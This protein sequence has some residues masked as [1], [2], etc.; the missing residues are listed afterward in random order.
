M[1][2]VHFGVELLFDQVDFG[3]KIGLDLIDFGI[4]LFIDQVDFG[5]KLGFEL[6]DLRVQFQPKL[7]DF[8]EQS[9]FDFPDP[10]FDIRNGSLEIFLG[11]TLTAEKMRDRLDVKFA[12]VRI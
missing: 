3:G 2:R 7:I 6:L 8:H 4:E 1:N 5:R 11:G 10:D 12:T 9:L